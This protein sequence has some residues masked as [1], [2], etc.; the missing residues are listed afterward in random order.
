M[1]RII[2]G[3]A[4][5]VKYTYS[6][7]GHIAN[8]LLGH[9]HAMRQTCLPYT[10]HSSVVYDVDA[11]VLYSRQD[12]QRRGYAGGANLDSLERGPRMLRRP[13][14]VIL[15]HFSWVTSTTLEE[16]FKTDQTATISSQDQLMALW[17]RK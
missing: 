17:I 8:H 6:T 2:I 4:S 15:T 5:G 11:Y 16:R 3:G 12:H 7:R 10:Q 9:S 13:Q 1:Y 14:A